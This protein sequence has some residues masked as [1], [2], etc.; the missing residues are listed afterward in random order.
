MKGKTGIFLL[1]AFLTS[2]GLGSTSALGK[3]AGVC[4]E[5]HSSATLQSMKDSSFGLDRSVYQARL[6]PCPGIR[7]L[8]E[9]N[10]F[11]ESRIVKVNDILGKIERQGRSAELLKTRTAENAESFSSLRDGEFPPAGRLARESSTLRAALEKVYEQTLLSR[12]ETTRRLLIGIGMLLFIGVMVLLGVGFRKLNRMGKALLAVGVLGG[13]MAAASCSPGPME[14]GGKSPA[15]EKLEQSLSVAAQ[16][17]RA[18][19][20]EFHRS[21]LLAQMA[22]DW[23]KMDPEGAEQAFRLA[24]KMALNAGEKAGELGAF[25]D[26]VSQISDRTEAGRRKVNFDTVL[27]LKDEIR[28]AEGRAWA[29]RAVAEE[30]VRAD[31]KRGRPALEAALQKALKIQDEEV[32]DRELKSAAEAWGATDPNE[33]REISL[34]IA[35]PFLKSMAL[36][37]IARSTANRDMAGDLVREAWKSAQLVSSLYLRSKASA[38]V[39]AAGAGVFPQEKKFW[40]D[41]SL[42]QIEKLKDPGLR[43]R[44][45]QNLIFEWAAIDNERAERWAD[46]LP[47]DFPEGRAYSFLRISRAAGVSRERAIGLVKKAW[48]EAEREPDAFE[49]R[50]IRMLA[51][52]GMAKL[53]LQELTRL[54]PG[55]DDPFFRSEV[56][57]EAA[58]ELSLRDPRKALEAAARIPLEPFRTRAAVRVVGIRA[59]GDR[60]K[61]LSLYKEALKA[62]ESIP[63]PYERALR[64]IELGKHWAA[65]EKGKE[66]LPLESARMAAEQIPS[67]S[68][69]AEVLDLLGSAWANSDPAKAKAALEKIDPSVSVARRSLAEVRLWAK[70]DPVR[71]GQRAN[72]ISS[73]FPYE[74]T[75]ALKEVA[76]GMKKNQPQ[77]ALSHLEDALQ[78]CLSLPQGPKQKKLLS[79]IFAEGAFLDKAWTLRKLAELPDPNVRDSL[80]RDTGT[81][82]AREDPLQALRAAREISESSLRLPVYQKAA[83]TAAQKLSR[84]GEEAK[85]PLLLGL[86]AWGRGREKAK[87]EELQAFPFLESA[88]EELE[89]VS[90][91]LER[92]CLLAGLAA[93]W[94]PLDEKKALSLA[95][96][97]PPAE[98]AEPHSYA[99]LQAGGQYRKWNRK[100]ADSLFQKTLLSAEKIGDRALKAKRLLQLALQWRFINPEKG[101]EVLSRVEKETRAAAPSGT[102]NPV[103][104]QVLQTRLE[105]NP[106]ESLEICRGAESS[107]MRSLALLEGARLLRAKTVEEDLKILEEALHSAERD[108]NFRL[109]ADI[110]SA[111][112]ELDPRKGLDILGRVDPKELRVKALRQIARARD[113]RTGEEVRQ[114]LDRAADEALA[115]EGLTQRLEL[116]KEIGRDWSGIDRD[117]AKAVYAK[118]FRIFEQEY[119]SSPR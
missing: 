12:D 27:D 76:V 116:L 55:I 67:V 54:I 40:A 100:E 91:P 13:S 11:T 68:A 45:L 42:S 56:L 28:S 60:Q 24:S 106:E 80:L 119:L 113:Q 16:V 9:D 110:G 82:W 90:D 15:Q 94:A 26:L 5:C 104:F 88:R 48:R 3:P 105:W 35:D 98:F 118:A 6:D 59:A 77:A 84:L 66:N 50:R 61:V 93:E 22:G 57:A 114:L 78:R 58:S 117:R 1:A 79:E 53:D 21:I 41:Q 8:A 25:R 62:A 89:K 19:E 4:V 36:V 64:L 37:K 30:W 7:S 109:M 69:R 20:D 43:N 85:S 39:S 73:S 75:L 49:S 74:K 97:I 108:K 2:P 47:A 14:P 101:K 46:G 107:A 111:W 95:E 18:V 112:Y 83:D 52:K 33:A 92:S 29:L 103:L 63:E 65:V 23:S 87:K 17:S 31:A 44:A 86:A 99:L 51:G 96:K 71:G 102:G 81:L 34:A 72:S 38:R 32:R 115:V 70:T 10:F